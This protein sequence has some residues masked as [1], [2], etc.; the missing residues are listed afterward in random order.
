MRRH[1]IPQEESCPVPDAL[2]GD[3]YRAS[4]EGLHALVESVPAEVRALLAVFC[5]RRAHL[6]TLGLAIA[7]TCEREQLVKS[8]GELGAHI[9]AQSRQGPPVI[10]EGRRKVT[11]TRRTLPH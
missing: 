9:F 10:A 7:S 5:S 1:E 4:P 3:L 6:A 8:G 2:L 11:L